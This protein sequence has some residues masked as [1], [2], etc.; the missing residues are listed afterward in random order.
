MSPNPAI[1]SSSPVA[2]VTGGAS[3][4]GAACARALAENGKFVVVADRNAS[5]GTALAS[6]IGGAFHQLDVTSEEQWIAL[7]DDVVAEQGSLDV[8]VNAAGIVG[9]VRH[10]TLDAMTL[11]DWRNVMSV[12]LDGTF[13]GCRE[14]MRPMKIQ[15]HGSIINLASLGA[16]YPTQQNAAYGASKGGVTSLTKTVAL[17]G[18]QDGARVRCNSVHP[19][20]IATPML[21]DI[22]SQKLERSAAREDGTEDPAVTNDSM[23]RLPLGVGEAQDVA[24]LIAFLASDASRYI[25]GSEYIIDGGWHLLR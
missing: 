23:N 14:A 24:D 19:G 18:S 3:G 10:G 8:L 17:F 11:D 25:T 7:V 22:K 20:Q 13:L 5:D 21:S 1:T 12:N 4:I 16:Y 9:D 6:A 15:G 2:I